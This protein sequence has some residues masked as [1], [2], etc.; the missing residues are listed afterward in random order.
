MIKM[1]IQTQDFGSLAGYENTKSPSNKPSSSPALL[2]IH[3]VCYKYNVMH[4]RE[5]STAD[6]TY[7]VMIRHES[8]R[9]MT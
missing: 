5:E 4:R 8:I 1:L 9:G 3:P 6:H 7:W 2:T